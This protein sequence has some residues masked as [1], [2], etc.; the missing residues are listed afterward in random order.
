[1]RD[2]S[3][4]WGTSGTKVEIPMR[5]NREHFTELWTN[6]M[7][8]DSNRK[9]KN[10]YRNSEGISV[11]MAIWH[12]KGGVQEACESLGS[13]DSGTV[14]QPTPPSNPQTFQA[15][16]FPFVIPSSPATEILSQINRCTSISIN[17]PTNP[18]RP[19]TSSIK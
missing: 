7:G 11:E 13:Q 18:V 14:K 8:Q 9:G 15:I 1:M 17:F 4:R 6:Y 2:Y 12:R 16:Q 5:V 3:D 19:T 10:R